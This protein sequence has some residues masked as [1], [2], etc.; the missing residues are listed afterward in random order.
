M[1]CII[2]GSVRIMRGY[3]RGFSRQVAS[4]DS[5]VVENGDFQYFW[6]LYLRYLLFRD[7][8]KISMW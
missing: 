1:D 6:S 7:K 4:N 5:G 3:L 8:T 2:S